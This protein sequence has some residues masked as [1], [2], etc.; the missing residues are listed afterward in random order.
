VKISRNGDENSPRGNFQTR[1]DFNPLTASIPGAAAL[2]LGNHREH[3]REVVAAG[4]AWLS[5]MRDSY[6]AGVA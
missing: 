4:A 2:N 5:K 3:R 6:W 1:R